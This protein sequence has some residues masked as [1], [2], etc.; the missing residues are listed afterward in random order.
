MTISSDADVDDV[1][2]IVEERSGYV[3]ELIYDC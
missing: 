3:D 1:V 2:D